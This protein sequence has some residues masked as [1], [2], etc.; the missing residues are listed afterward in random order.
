[1]SSLLAGLSSRA[2]RTIA[3]GLSLAGLALVA[4]LTAV[5]IRTWTP[6]LVSAAETPTPGPAESPTPAPTSTVVTNPEISVPGTLVYVK[7]GTLW[8]QTGTAA[9]PLMANP[10]GSTVSQPTWSS[11]GQWIYYIDTR[12]STGRWYDPDNGNAIGTYVLNVA[13]LCRIHPDGLGKEDILSSLIRQ[14]SLR[15]FYWIKQPSVSPDGSAV[16]VISDGPTV[17]G[18]Q[19]PM[20]H[21]ISLA[22]RKL[23]PALSLPES[24]PL[25]LAD[26]A[27]S[28]DGKLLAYVEEGRSGGRG[29]PSIWLYNIGGRSTRRLVTGYRGPSWSPDGKYLAVTR[30][31][32]DALDVAVIDAGNGRLIAQ[33]THDGLSWAPVWSPAGDEL[34]YM[35]MNGAE[36]DLN[37]VRIDTSGANMTFRIEPNLTEYS[38]L[39]G[40]SRAAWY[41]PGVGPAAPTATSSPVASRSSTPAV[42][43]I[44]SPS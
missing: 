30:V 9:R 34:V 4:V 13:V 7:D 1:V 31:S 17:P 42:S 11:D 14:G 16:A 19:D 20:I 39:D 24:S 37:M 25:G 2:R 43:P 12:V 3:P 35:H 36:V 32:G 41:I 22:S 15:T 21:F 28:P 26:P 40:G 29:N 5:A 6:Q 38:G 8:V 27:Y 18:V 44:A 10:P 33:I 23:G